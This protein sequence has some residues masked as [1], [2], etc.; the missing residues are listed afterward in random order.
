MVW[1]GVGCLQA[2]RLH[3]LTTESLIKAPEAR[4][5]A[6]SLD[7]A[8]GEWQRPDTAVQCTAGEICQHASITSGHYAHIRDLTKQKAELH[9]ADDR[10][11]GFGARAELFSPGGPPPPSSPE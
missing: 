6:S 4:T 5:A 8:S 2:P 11:E 3:L 1:C 10:L 7:Q 9:V